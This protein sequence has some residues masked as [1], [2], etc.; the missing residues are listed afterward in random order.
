MEKKQLKKAVQVSATDYEKLLSKEGSKEQYDKLIGESPAELRS[1]LTSKHL[2]MEDYKDLVA[3]S[4]VFTLCAANLLPPGMKQAEAE[5]RALDKENVLGLTTEGER[6]L[7]EN[8]ALQAAYRTAAIPGLITNFWKN[9]RENPN[10]WGPLFDGHVHSL[11][12]YKEEKKAKKGGKEITRRVAHD[13]LTR[14]VGHDT[15]NELVDLR[16]NIS[17][18][19]QKVKR[20]TTLGLYGKET[21]KLVEEKVRSG[22]K[23]FSEVQ[24]HATERLQQVISARPGIFESSVRQGGTVTLPK[25]EDELNTATSLLLE[26]VELESQKK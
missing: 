10:W 25:T 18:N 20:F 21:I 17:L 13:R 8:V 23:K 4:G 2:S 24:K 14:V 15:V 11:R 9:Y 1:L 12:L 26:L 3:H 22:E 6:A 5:L 7:R 19:Q 16:K